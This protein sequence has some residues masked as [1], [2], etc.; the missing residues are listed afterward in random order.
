MALLA[1]QIMDA[2]ILSSMNGRVELSQFL[3][4]TNESIVSQVNSDQDDNR[5]NRKYPCPLCG[6][7]F[8]FNS[9][10]SLHMRTHTGEK[11]FKCPYCDH[12]AAQKGNLKIHLR[13]H[14][15]GLLGKGR[16]RIREENRLLH[17]LE[18]RAILRDRQMRAGHVSQ[19]QTSN[20]PQLKNPQLSQ[21][22]PTPNQFLS[23]SSAAEIQPHTSTSPEATTVQE[24]PVQPQP[25]GF[26][27]SFCKGKFRKQQE[28]ERHIRIL[29]K[30]YKCTLCEFAASHEE[31]LIGHVEMAHITADSGSGQKPPV[32]TG[33]KGKPA[34]EFPCEV[35]GQTFSQAWF[36]KGHMRKHKDSF[37]HC[38]QI[39]G[40]RFKEPWFLKN[41]MKVHLNKL[42]AKSNLPAEHDPYKLSNLSQEH[43]SNLYSQY[44]SRIHNRFLA[45]ERAEHP[46]YNQVLTT[47]G[48]DMKVRE[49]LGRMIS[50]GPLTDAESSSLLALNHLPPQL[51]SS[52]M[53]YLQKVMSSREAFNSS[54]GYPGWQ[55]M[56]QVL[57]VEQQMFNPKDQTS[58]L[59][60]R[61]LPADDGKLCLSDP[62]TKTISR[63][64]STGSLSHHGPTDIITETGNSL[65]GSALDQQPRPS[66]PASDV[67]RHNLWRM[68]GLRLSNMNNAAGESHGTLR[69]LTRALE[70]Q[71]TVTFWH[72]A[73]EDNLGRI[74][75]FSRS[76]LS[77]YRHD[78]HGNCMDVGPEH[79]VSS[80][81]DITVIHQDFVFLLKDN[82]I[83]LNCEKVYR[84]PL[85][86]DYTAAQTASLGFHLD[87]YHF[88]HWQ[89]SRDLSSPLQPSS[90]SSSSSPNSKLRPRSREDW[91]PAAGHYQGLENHRETPLLVNKQ[92]D[93]T[94]K[95]VDG[96]LSAQTSK[97]QYEP[98]DL[99]VRPESVPSH[100]A[101]SP[102]VLVQMSGVFSNGLSSS[103]TRRLQSYPNAAAEL[104][105]KPGYQCDLLVQATKEEM[106]TQRG[107]SACHNG[108]GEFEKSEQGGEDENDDAA[109]WQML[110]NN[111]PELQELLEHASTDFPGPE[112]QEK[113]GQWGRGV[114]ESPIHSLENLTPG[115]ADPLQYQGGLLSFLRAQGSLSGAPASAHSAGLNPGGNMEN[116]VASGHEGRE[117]RKPFQCRY[118]P[119][120]ASQKGNLKTH[121]LC[122]HRKPFDNSLY[123]DRRLRR[124][125]APRGPSRLP[126]SM[127]GDQIGMTSL[128][129]L[130]TPF[131]RHLLAVNQRGLPGA[132]D[133]A[134]SPCEMCLSKPT[135]S[136]TPSPCPGTLTF[137]HGGPLIP[138]PITDSLVTRPSGLFT[139]QVTRPAPP[140]A[141]TFEVSLSQPR[142]EGRAMYG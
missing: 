109:K 77:G 73:H 98:L 39:C 7:R 54:S 81:T 60:E 41:H 132:I 118:C 53:E 130:T 93:L 30:P 72:T 119:Y 42:A 21:T 116:E 56:T 4:V 107:G 115:Q 49:M 88:P 136:A 66:S 20:L 75:G 28:L 114:A 35:C 8:R 91:S 117:A 33:D 125:H 44:I 138:D 1:N 40:R 95:H 3:R 2:R 83:M 103:I 26:R 67:F 84:C 12:R 36:L 63:P 45:A 25:T 15:Q 17:E 80:T 123:P 47:A 89:N 71:L 90:S 126:P 46:D 74:T 52:G 134:V 87:R 6:K 122:V 85:S 113:P 22:V 50:S 23:N 58:Y 110:K 137:R 76:V 101:M 10:L 120:S 128:C 59:S 29:H 9:I 78:D 135:H 99:S 104:S 82:G 51:S 43:Q 31:E 105:G 5:K 96:S 16:G 24:E 11:P 86:S 38:C 111:V 57:P 102:A 141:T 79:R 124:S 19:Q 127:L 100:S 18:E 106:S 142:G 70:E 140:A 14:K 69:D 61:C 62:D 32:G 129:G 64:G 97:S 131:M 48:V 34:G 112:M 68:S 133:G 37:E 13:T 108:E 94:D 65:S 139:R 27:C 55:M 121:V 92:P